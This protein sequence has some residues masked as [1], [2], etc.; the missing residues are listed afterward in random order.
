MNRN[1]KIRFVSVCNIGS[2]VKFHKPVSLTSVNYF[3][4]F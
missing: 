1:E 3:Y 2:F 4:I